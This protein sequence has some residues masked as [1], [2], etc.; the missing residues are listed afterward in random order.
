[1]HVHPRLP[2]ILLLFSV[3]GAMAAGAEWVAPADAGR[4]RAV[5]GDRIALDIRYGII[6]RNTLRGPER[7]ARLDRALVATDALAAEFL[8]GK[9][10]DAEDQR[11]LADRMSALFFRRRAQDAVALYEAFLA[12]G[13]PVPAWARRDVAGSYL[14][15]RKAQ[16]AATLYREVIAADPDD[17]EANLGLFYAL[18][19]CEELDLA[20]AHIDAF[21][22]RLPERRHRD[23]RY[24]G[25]R[26]SANIT[27][28]QARIYSDRL[29]EAQARIEARTAASPFNSEARQ[30]AA[31]L[32][33][34]RGWQRQ[35]EQLLRRIEGADPENPAV[36]ADL[37]E[38]RL[39]LQDWAAAKESF[40][41]AVA[42]DPENSGVR[43]A[44][45]TLALHNR[46]EFFS[47]AGYGRGQN[48]PFSGN[49]DW[50]ID[51]WLYSPP[52]A[53]EWRIFA[54]NFTS[55]AD[56]DGDTTKWVR[57]GIGAEWRGRDWRVTGEVNDGSGEKAGLTATARWKADDYWTFY[58]AAETVTNQIPLRAV[59]SDVRASRASAGGDWQAN[60]SRKLSA[61]IAAS[62]FSDGNRRSSVNAA[63]FERWYS[64]PRWMFE[65]TLGGDASHN[66]LDTGASYFNPKND[67]SLWLT[68]AVENLTWRNYERS[69]RQRL[70]LTGGRY[71][72]E[73]YPSGSI[74]AIEYGHRW[75]LE[76]D[77]SVRYGI[78]R[79]LRPYDGEREARTFA[80][81]NVL[82]R[83]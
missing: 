18:V 41:R 80:N 72:Q 29:Q 74:E 66:T 47:E 45:E 69:F 10:A 34:A 57:T 22:A 24:N 79:S 32:A 51:S 73:Y 43:R 27:A 30:A 81:L 3:G 15:L 82:W 23:G 68:A 76:R 8:A 64:S 31:S 1:M 21:A 55:S 67:H 6:D 20:T 5:A 65:T 25:E 75:E 70:A 28:D 49:R 40:D 56:L 78:G 71:W 54:H 35:G 17:F 39:G 2:L 9:A 48:N 36:K 53:A 77:L 19:E 59:Q 83:F 12:R 52:L 13:L 33:L 37:A 58:G 62:N 4:Q 61:G 14:A 50:S 46:F 11:R 26:L 63:W 60:E 42:L 7:F 38:V 44:R 16:N